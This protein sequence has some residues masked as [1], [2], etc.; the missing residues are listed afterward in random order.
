MT[1]LQSDNTRE[2]WRETKY[3]GFFISNLGRVKH[4]KN[5]DEK[6]LKPFLHSSGRY[7]LVNFTYNGRQI[8]VRIAKLVALAF[9]GEVADGACVVNA[10]GD[11][12]DN[13]PENVK[14]FSSL[15]EVM[16]FHG[17]TKRLDAQKAI[18]ERRELRR[19]RNEKIIA[20]LKDSTITGVAQAS[21]LS[22]SMVSRIKSGER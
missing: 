8:G 11:L 3:A 2:E 16:R 22:V 19:K 14:I 5:S 6:I 7:L 9:V 21:G 18:E 10:N 12:Y 13:T 1:Q 17:R 20:Q 4:M 15:K